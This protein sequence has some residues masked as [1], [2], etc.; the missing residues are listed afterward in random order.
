MQ[1]V[2]GSPDGVIRIA[3]RPHSSRTS[4][5]LLWRPS[6]WHPRDG[7]WCPTLRAEQPTAIARRIAASPALQG[8]LMA[9]D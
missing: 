8:A 4:L 9:A 2:S 5:G 6:P 7:G 3:N 1:K